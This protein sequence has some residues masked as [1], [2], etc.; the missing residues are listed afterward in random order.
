VV[1]LGVGTIAAYGR[2]GDRIRF[3]EINPQVLQLAQRHFS[4]LTDCQGQVEVVLGDARLSMEREEPQLFD[5][6]ALDAFSGDAI[7]VHLLTWEAIE[8]YLRHMKE[9]GVIA[10]HISNKY[11]NLEPVVA[12]LAQEFGLYA[13][14]INHPSSDYSSDWILLMRKEKAVDWDEIGGHEPL[15]GK[16]GPLWTDDYASLLQIL[17]R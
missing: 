13:R 10:V 17:H 16:S 7:P 15:G 8:I 11:L 12:R 1:G 9:T 14:T 2:E 4:Y 3:Y 6:L 5:V